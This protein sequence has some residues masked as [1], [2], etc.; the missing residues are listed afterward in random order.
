MEQAQWQLAPDEPVRRMSATVRLGLILGLVFVLIVVVGG[1]IVAVTNLRVGTVDLVANAPA[2]TSVTVSIPNAQLD[3][4]PG[5]DDR[6]RVT[7]TGRYLGAV[8]RLSADTVDGVTTITGGCPNQWF[9]FCQ[10]DLSVSLPASV[11]LAVTSTNGKIT[12][13]G[14]TGPLRLTTTNGA[15]QADGT[16]DRIEL[17]T[18]NGAISVRDSSTGEAVATT[19]NGSVELVF[20]DP[21]RQVEARSTNGSVTV[22]V[23]DDGVA[24]RVQAR[25]SNGDVDTG[26]VPS[27]PGAARRIV[28]ETTNGRVAVRAE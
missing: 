4:R 21:P 24:Y 15:I 6:V 10:L 27:D 19:T 14:L 5:N 1:V 26:S 20:R 22:R 25:T 12:T 23:P 13:S 16:R 8:P 9:G 7:A 3:F 18:T 11:A 28:A 17:H 2:G